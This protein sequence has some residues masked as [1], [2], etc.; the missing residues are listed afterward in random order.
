MLWS[1]WKAMQARN[2]RIVDEFMAGKTMRELAEEHKLSKPRISQIIKEAGV[3]SDEGGTALLKRRML[4][5]V[6]GKARVKRAKESN[7]IL[8]TGATA[9]V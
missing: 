5:A 1:E 7:P 6:R 4:Q 3:D 9:A 8:I 2:E